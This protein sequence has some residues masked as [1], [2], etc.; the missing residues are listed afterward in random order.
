MDS[1]WVYRKVELTES[2][3]AA[4][5][6]YKKASSTAVRKVSLKAMMWVD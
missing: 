5:K 3:Q 2:Q 1:P 4:L 6:V